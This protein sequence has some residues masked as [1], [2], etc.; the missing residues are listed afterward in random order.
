MSAIS[1]K[2][3]I[4]SVVLNVENAE[5]MKNFYR[6]IIGLDI[7]SES[8]DEIAFGA[9]HNDETFLILRAG[10]TI[11]RSGSSVTGM[12]HFAILV[13][14]RKDLGKILY[15]LLKT[16]YPITGASDHGYSEALYLDDPEGNGIEI[17]RDKPKSEWDIRPDGEIRGVTEL[18]DADGVI[19]A[20]K[21]PF[22]GMAKDTHIGHIHLFVSDLGKSEYFY[23]NVLGF[24]LKTNF[25]SKAKFFAAGEYHHHI[26]TNIWAG[27]NIPPA[28]KGAAGMDHYVIAVG[29]AAELSK[30]A[31]RLNAEKYSHVYDEAEKVLSLTDPNGISIKLTAE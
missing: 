9:Y 6:G 4:E 19:A 2:T 10:K 5:N 16:K 24:D 22:K 23:K 29:S 27:E 17:Y 20:A 30:L 13:P 21:D 18:M 25:G 15:H 28:E 31:D 7:K 11:P 14:S 8:D 26:G 1:E 12:Y 3:K